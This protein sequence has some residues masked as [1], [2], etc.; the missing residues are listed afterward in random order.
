MACAR[1]SPT[2]CPALLQEV[3]RERHGDTSERPPVLARKHARTND[4]PAIEHGAKLSLILGLY[5]EN[6]CA[7]DRIEQ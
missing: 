7:R 2:C 5:R 3:G 1:C 4:I 6:G